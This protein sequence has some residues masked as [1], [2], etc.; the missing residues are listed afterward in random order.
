MD[1][2]N[3]LL[4]SDFKLAS[5]CTKKLVYKKQDHLTAQ[6]SNEFLES[7]AKGSHIVGKAPSLLMWRFR[8]KS[9]FVGGCCEGDD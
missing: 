3:L 9:S 8:S 7:L 4:K 5:S 1:S 6:D 2:T